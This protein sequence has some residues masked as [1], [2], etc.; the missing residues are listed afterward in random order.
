[1][2][3]SS[4]EPSSPGELAA[5]FSS[6]NE[7]PGDQFKSSVFRNADQSNVGRSLL[8]GNIICSV[9][10]SLNLWDTNI[11]LGLSLIVSVSYSKMLML[12]DWNY[13]T[14]NTDTL[15]LDENKFA[16]KK[17]YLWRKRFSEILRSDVCTKWKKWRE[18]KNYELTKSQY[19]NQDKTMRQYRTSLHQLQEMQEQMNSMNGSGEL[20]EVESNYSGRLSH[21]SSQPAKIPSSRSMLSSDKTLAS[22]HMEYIG[23][24]GTVFGNL[25]STFDSR[26]DHHPPLRTTKGTRIRPT[27]HRVGDTFQNRWQT[28]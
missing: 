27:G 21:V 13:K 8:E 10:Q 23:F 16:Y 17:N 11:N 7:E 12:R 25:F 24:A 9:K 6:G 22:W 2:S 14:H 5:L 4:Q 20:Q 1:M 19:T 15:N 18:L 3:S 26:R 28:K